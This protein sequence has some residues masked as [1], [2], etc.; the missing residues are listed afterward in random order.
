ME[1]KTGQKIVHPI[2]IKN[3]TIHLLWEVVEVKKDKVKIART[4]SNGAENTHVIERSQIKSQEILIT[5]G[6]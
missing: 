4:G 5:F 2:K 1:I 6:Y 3:T